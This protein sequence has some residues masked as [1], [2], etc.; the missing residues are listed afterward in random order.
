MD[1]LIH[2]QSAQD[3]IIHDLLYD[4]YVR[5]FFVNLIHHNGIYKSW[6]TKTVIRLTDQRTIN[7]GTKLKK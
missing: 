6:K 3:K 4:K 2:T 5:F 7:K 1:T